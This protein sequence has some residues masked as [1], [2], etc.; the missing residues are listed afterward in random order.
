MPTIL[1]K[2]HIIPL[3]SDIMFKMVFMYNQDILQ[4][5]VCDIIHFNGKVNTFKAVSGAELLPTHHENR[6]YITDLIVVINKKKMVKIEV[7][8]YK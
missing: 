4:Q 5:M 1:E 3:S 7:N 2:D 6:K 8:C